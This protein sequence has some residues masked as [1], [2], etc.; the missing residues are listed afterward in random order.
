MRAMQKPGFCSLRAC[1]WRYFRIFLTASSRA[2]LES[3]GRVCARPRL[4]ETAFARGRVWLAHR[5]LVSDFAPLL[6]V[7]LLSDR[8]APG[9]DWLKFRRFAAYHAYS[10]KL[11]GLLL[12]SALFWLFV[13]GRKAVLR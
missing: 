2:S 8:A 10:G 1:F 11:A 4:R 9:F 3:R 7:W 6:F 12:V 5:D 13:F